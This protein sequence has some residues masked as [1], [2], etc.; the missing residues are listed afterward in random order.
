MLSRDAVSPA[1][2]A[3]RSS[4]LSRATGLG[5]SRRSTTAYTLRVRRLSC[6]LCANQS[7]AGPALVEP[8]TYRYFPPRSN[9]GCATSLSPSVTGVLRP[10]SASHS[11]RRDTSGRVLTV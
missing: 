5:R 10:L 4:S 9:A 11:A 6:V 7:R 8:N 2:G 1:A 3:A